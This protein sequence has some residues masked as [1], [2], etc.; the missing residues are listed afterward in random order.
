MPDPEQDLAQF[1]PDPDG[2]GERQR[3]D[4]EVAARPPDHPEQWIEW[5]GEADASAWAAGELR[6]MTPRRPGTR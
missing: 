4:E 2:D 1:E 3:L 5:P 6:S